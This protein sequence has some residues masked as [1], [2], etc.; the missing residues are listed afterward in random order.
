[1]EED[2]RLNEAGGWVIWRPVVAKGVCVGFWVGVADSESEALDVGE[3][4][5]VVGGG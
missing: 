2:K 3:G 5:G 1:M 4:V